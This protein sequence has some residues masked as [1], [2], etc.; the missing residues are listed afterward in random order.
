MAEKL[1]ILGIGVSMHKTDGVLR[2]EDFCKSYGLNYQIVG[3]G[4]EWRGGD[5]AISAGG[6]QKINELL[7]AI[8]NLENQLIIVCDTFDLIPVAGEKEILDKY[9][10][11]CTNN[12]VLF[13]SE[14]VCWPDKNLASVYP[15]VNTKYK[16][17]N[18]GSFMGYRDDIYRMICDGNILDNDDDQ[19][20]FSLKYIQGEKIILDHSCHI[21]QA[22]NAVA[23]DLSIHRNRI[24]NKYTNSYP[25]FLHGNGPAKLH[26]NRFENYLVSNIRKNNTFTTVTKYKL[27]NQPKIFFALYIDSNK[28]D[29][30]HQFIKSVL[31][32]D[33]DNKE[34]HI[35]DKNRNIN[36]QVATKEMNYHYY[37]NISNYQMDHFLETDCEYY[38]LLEQQCIIIKKDILHELIPKFSAYQRIISPLLVHQEKNTFSNFWGSIN[39][40]GYYQ[41][42]SDYFDLLERNKVGL[43]NVPHVSG[44]ILMDRS[45]ISNFN[46][47]NKQRK[48]GNDNDMNLCYYCRRETVFLYMINMHQYG[49]LID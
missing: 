9:H 8:E 18:S 33:Y 24:Y 2:F 3:E 10:S 26:L 6:G 34:I 23:D 47:V 35:Y 37:H 14:T 15:S 41:R 49:Y 38:F 29:Q 4:K 5:L 31:E 43:W 11:I 44:A 21:F 36:I 27:E 17:L 39:N 20:Y 22:I 19:L 1:L 16:Y 28:M 48:Y 32:I 42:S 46:L 12:Q 13:S 45:V 40:S 30:Y 7:G 25:I